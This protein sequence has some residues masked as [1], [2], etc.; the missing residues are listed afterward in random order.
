MTTVLLR[1]ACLSRSSH[2]AFPVSPR[3]ALTPELV[4]PPGQNAPMRSPE[5]CCHQWGGRTWASRRSCQ[6]PGLSLWLSLTRKLPQPAK[7]SA[8][9]PGLHLGGDWRGG[10]G[11]MNCFTLQR[12]SS[13]CLVVKS[14]KEAFGH[15]KYHVCAS[16]PGFFNQLTING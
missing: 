2:A 3:P 15:V 4:A 1:S 13:F 11:D 8:S 5:A 10:G 6:G 7:A 14:Y 16:V 12:H 9:S